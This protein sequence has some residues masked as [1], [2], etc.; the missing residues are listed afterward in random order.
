ML[1]E[2]TGYDAYMFKSNDPIA[3]TL[4]FEWTAAGLAIS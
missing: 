3:R 4:S 1:K 2:K